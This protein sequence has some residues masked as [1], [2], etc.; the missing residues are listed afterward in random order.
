M[1]C[2]F[3][4]QLAYYRGRLED[5]ASFAY[6]TVYTAESTSQHLLGMYGAR[7]LA[8][9]AVYQSDVGE[10]GYALRT[11]RRLSASAGGDALC[12][13]YHKLIVGELT[14]LLGSS[15]EMPFWLRDGSFGAVRGDGPFG[16]RYRLSNARFPY[17]VFPFALLGHVRY[18]IRAHQYRRVVA[19]YEYQ[20]NLGVDGIPLLGVCLD[21]SCASAL[22]G[23]NRREEAKALL[24][25]AADRIAPDGLWLLAAEYAP[26]TGGLFEEVLHERNRNELPKYGKLTAMFSAGLS[27]LTRDIRSGELSGELTRREYETAQL[28]AEGK[29]NAEIAAELGISVNTVKMHLKSVFEKLQIKRRIELTRV[30]R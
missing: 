14:N 17:L 9:I 22:A 18:L 13:I 7:L 19:V 25:A 27:K 29:T 3:Q 10:W 6:R 30:L 12:A 8:H 5:A 2:L 1:E 21:L 24:A 11:I 20:K 28:A 26:H 23:L 15:D 16:M 4:A